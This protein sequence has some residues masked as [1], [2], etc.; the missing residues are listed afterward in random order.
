MACDTITKPGIPAQV[1]RRAAL[2]WFSHPQRACGAWRGDAQLL[3]RKSAELQ[4]NATGELIVIQ[5]PVD[6]A[7]TMDL[8]AGTESLMEDADANGARCCGT[9][10][11]NRHSYNVT[12]SLEPEHGML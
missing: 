10:Y 9:G 11:L 7:H 1:K 6:I 5:V 4:R 12:V 3:E 2:R 8:S